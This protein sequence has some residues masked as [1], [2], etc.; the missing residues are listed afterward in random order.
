MLC[1]F[2]QKVL[3]YI[4][5]RRLIAAEENVL[6]AIS[7]GADSIALLHCL[8]SLKTEGRLDISFTCAHL[9][10]QLRGAESDADE[11]FVIEQARNLGLEVST[12]NLSVRTFAKD[13]KL[14]VETAARQ[15]RINA[16]LDIAHRNNCKLIATGHQKNDNAET[17]LQRLLRGTGFRGMGGIWP[18]RKFED[19]TFISPLLD[20]TREQIA[21]YLKK[22]N[23]PWQLDATNE[24]CIYHRNFIR[25]QLMPEIQ[26]DCAD[27]IIE[28][29]SK[30]SSIAQKFHNRIHDRTQSIWSKLTTATPDTVKLDIEGLLLEPEPVQIELIRLS[31]TT[32]GSGER[33]LVRQHYE[34]VLQLC[35][36]K[37]NNKLIELPNGFK[38]YRQYQQL[39]FTSLHTHKPQEL[40]DKTVKL[41]V[42]GKTQ[43]ADYVIEATITDFDVALFEKFKA[44]KNGLI[45]W[46]DFGKLSL[47]LTVRSRR[48]GDRFTPLG[49]NTEKKVGKFLTNV[50]MPQDLRKNVLIVTDTE[51]IIWLG[52]IR[53]SNAA[54]VS[55]QTDKIL[56]LQIAKSQPSFQ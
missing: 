3:D 15:L 10:H 16:L 51:K 35:R 9:N 11:K 27:S 7:G 47:P 1:E 32:I 54:S 44:Q 37:I 14:S 2:E 42:P 21:D 34:R 25:H 22:R 4:T 38:V 52:P 50:K 28:Q 40:S 43:F 18:S 31:L 49:Q 23:L 39:I 5:A 13:N 30:L 33:D 53:I 56:Q 55:S 26:K 46:F 41:N 24:Q 48:P 20:V 6:L 12:K 36:Q 19:I 8:Y 45:E 29:L 17:V